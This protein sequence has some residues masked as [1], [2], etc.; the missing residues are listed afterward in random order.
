M[1]NNINSSVNKNY[2]SNTNAGMHQLF[3]GDDKLTA[4]YL[5]LIGSMIN[6]FL[7]MRQR[8]IPSHQI[9]IHLSI[10]VLIGFL[11]SGL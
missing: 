10:I 9:A 5:I 8:K 11:L 6:F 2:S 1:T 7:N 4:T 3:F